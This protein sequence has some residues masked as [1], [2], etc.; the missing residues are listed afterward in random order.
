MQSALT[1]LEIAGKLNRIPIDSRSIVKE[2]ALSENEPS[3]EELTR[4]AKHQGFRSSIKKLSIEKIVKNYPLPAIVLKKDGSYMSI[5]QVNEEKQE[6]LV[7][8]TSSKEP[9]VMNYIDC[10]NI[11]SGK[12]IVLR[13]KMLS[14]QVK[15]GFG[16]FYAQM[17][18]YKKIIGEVLLASLILQLFG[19]VTPLF[20]QVIL[21]KVLVHRSMTTLDVLAIAFVAVALFDFIINLVRNYIFVHTTSKID[22]KLGAKL[23]YHLLALPI[24]YFEKRKVGNIIARVRELDTIREFIANKSISVILDV[25]FSG[26]F[27]AVMLMYSVKLTMLVVAFV[28]V[29]GILYF[30][31]TPQLRKRLEE[32]F[33]MGAQS[34]AY[35]V[36]SVT[37]VQTVKSLALEGS[38]QRKWED[39]LAKY[40][41][42]SFHLSNLSNVLGGLSGMLQKLMTIS[43]LYVG[44]TLVLEGKLS[45]GQLIAFQ[46]FANQFSGPVLRLV[47]LWNEFQQTLLSV[48][49]IGDILNTP[50]EQ[51]ND[52]AITLPR[53]EGSVKFDNIGFSYTPEMPNVLNG[54]SA[55]FKAGQSVGLVGRSGSGKSTITKLIQ[56]LY[57]PNSGTIYIDSVDIRHM[58]PKWLRNNIGVVLQE[59]FLFS[60]TIK[61]NIS[62][63]RPD[64]PIEDIIH[65]SKMA[66]AHEFISELPEGY[67]SQVGERGGSLSGGQK[68]RIAIARALII[69]PR[70]LIFDEATSALDYESE[71]I[72]QNNMDTIKNGRTMFIVAHRLTT[73]KHCDV[74]LVMDKGN[75]VESGTH[76]ELIKLHGYYHKLYTQQD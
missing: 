25:L 31:I 52:K 45:V 56:R 47:N 40:I 10:E 16:W 6:L 33:Q 61:D 5:I 14:Q 76:D 2:Y 22:A 41:N 11:S 60:G 4:I 7:F 20:T 58:N 38:M 72:I 53:I 23:F 67:D 63:S 62:L 13:H 29:I 57:V 8:D 69:N 35:L 46:M 9:Y 37:G 71:K 27:V 15:F 3:I 55:E 44:V 59:N 54:I 12:T 34:N 42:S 36:E 66:G 39:Y 48:D 17:L 43:M 32:K 75:I 51:K 64:A 65:V 21:D 28:S 70:I 1:A 18:N 74:I 49:R 19:L 26:V 30:F 50:T 73:V 68:Q 24:A